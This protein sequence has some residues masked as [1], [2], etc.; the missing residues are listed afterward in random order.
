MAAGVLHNGFLDIGTSTTLAINN[1]TASPSLGSAVDANSATDHHRERDRIVHVVERLREVG[2]SLE[3]L[4]DT[5]I[6]NEWAD[7]D[8]WLDVLRMRTG[9]NGSVL[10]RRSGSVQ[11][12]QNTSERSERDE[13]IEDEV[14]ERLGSLVRPIYTF[15][16][17]NR[18]NLV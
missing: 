9:R 15:Y 7:I 1:T 6:D 2:R 11:Q 13:E 17:L 8:L 5:M 4:E 14:M 16:Y 10:G 3:V 18:K 12:Q